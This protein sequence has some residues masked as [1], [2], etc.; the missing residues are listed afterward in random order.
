MQHRIYNL[1]GGVKILGLGT[2]DLV[3]IV[4]TWFITFQIFGATLQPRLRFLVGFA[5]TFL[6]Y[7]LW[8]RIKDRV[9]RNFGYHLIAWLGERPQYE[10]THDTEPSPYL[11]DVGTVDE[12]RRRQKRVDKLV[13]TA[14]KRRR[15]LAH[16]T[17]APETGDSS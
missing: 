7:H 3:V 13:R 1:D 16:N 10:V 12:L 17:P 6:A 15:K 11:I 4:F 8:I 5:A 9:P 14:I 2:G